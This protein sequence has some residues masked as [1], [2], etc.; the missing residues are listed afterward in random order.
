MT[1]PRPDDTTRFDAVVAERSLV[2][3][4]YATSNGLNH[5]GIPAMTYGDLL[6]DSDT[7]SMVRLGGAVTVLVVTPRNVGVA[8]T[9]RNRLERLG[10]PFLVVSE[11]LDG[12][13]R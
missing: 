7:G 1:V 4:D 8:G 11:L 9:A 12:S 13:R 2:V 10:L 6:R 5:A 3:D